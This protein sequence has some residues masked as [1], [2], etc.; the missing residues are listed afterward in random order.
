MH[1]VMIGSSLVL[2]KQLAKTAYLKQSTQEQRLDDGLGLALA[3]ANHRTEEIE[4]RQKG[5][6]ASVCNL[7]NTKTSDGVTQSQNDIWCQDVHITC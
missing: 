3:P 1:C 2:N 5:G 7:T 6:G 4:G